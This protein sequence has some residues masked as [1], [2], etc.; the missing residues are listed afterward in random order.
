MK[1][2]GRE[3]RWGSWGKGD[4]GGVKVVAAMLVIK[5]LQ[6]IAAENIWRWESNALK[7]TKA[8]CGI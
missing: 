2:R 4:S 5:A 1:G 6:V 7:K 3:P 8:V